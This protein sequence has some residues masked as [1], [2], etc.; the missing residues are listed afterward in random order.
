M[1]TTQHPV[2]LFDGVCNLC[3]A[4]VQWVL[5]HDRQGIFHFASLQSESGKELLIKHGLN[6]LQFDSVVLVDD[7]RYFLR[8]DAAFEILRRLG[9]S[10]RFLTVFQWFPRKLRDAVYNFIARNRYRWWGKRETC[11]IPRPEWKNRFLSV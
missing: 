9:G 10:W 5:L 6:P 8:S 7:A 11:M 2:L 1:Q 3:N 4:S